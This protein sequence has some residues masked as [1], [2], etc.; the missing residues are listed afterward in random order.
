MFPKPGGPDESI[1]ILNAHPQDGLNP[2]GPTTTVAFS[3]N[4]LYKVMIDTDADNIVL[5]QTVRI[6]RGVTAIL[7]GS[8]LR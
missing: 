7:E 1:L 4:A 5:P 2:K 3:T 8:M 6:E